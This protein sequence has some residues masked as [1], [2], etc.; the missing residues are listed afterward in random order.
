MHLPLQITL[1]HILVAVFPFVLSALSIT[2]LV[3]TSKESDRIL[4]EG[5]AAGQATRGLQVFLLR[6]ERAWREGTKEAAEMEKARFQGQL[7]FLRRSATD[8]ESLALLRELE[9]ESTKFFAG[10]RSLQSAE[11]LVGD[12]A[13]AQDESLRIKS[14]QTFAMGQDGIGLMVVFGSMSLVALL[15]F[16]YWMVR[17]VARPLDRMSRALEAILAG[18]NQRRLEDHGASLAVC[19]IGGGVNQLV[20]RLQRVESERGIEFLLA[21][22]AVEKLLDARGEA[23]ALLTP[24]KRLV[25]ANEQARE[26]IRARDAPFEVIAASMLEAAPSR[27]K[28]IRLWAPSGL[29]LG[30]LV[31]ISGDSGKPEGSPGA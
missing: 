7:G 29:R 19:R 18:D 31:C 21:C 14:R 30:D 15:F 16:G 1:G 27:V 22:S 28:E 20:D 23:G 25:A 4:R 26:L 10:G 5:Q 13:N 12:L 8:K 3:E 17:N 11:K 6:Y 2:F 24:G 9:V